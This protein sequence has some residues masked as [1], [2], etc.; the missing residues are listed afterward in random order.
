MPT[1]K[2]ITLKQESTG[3]TLSRD[4][5]GH[6]FEVDKDGVLQVKAEVTCS[7]WISR[8]KYVKPPARTG[9]TVDPP[10][11]A[12]KDSSPTKAAHAT[13]NWQ[14]IDL[15]ANSSN[16]L[17][18]KSGTFLWNVCAQG[19]NTPDFDPGGDGNSGS[20]SVKSG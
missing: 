20:M 1:A 17:H 13:T 11:W 18:L 14:R 10:S 9:A 8:D 5:E 12:I 4:N 16:E 3:Y 2:T 6:P 7:F 15:G 19:G